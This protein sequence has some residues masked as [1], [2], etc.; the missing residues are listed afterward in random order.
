MAAKAAYVAAPRGSDRSGLKE[1]VKRAHAGL[2]V[3][4]LAKRLCVRGA[5][6]LPWWRMEAQGLFS[7][8]EQLGK[9]AGPP[10]SCSSNSH[11]ATLSRRLPPS[12]TLLLTHPPLAWQC[13]AA[14]REARPQREHH[15]RRPQ[16]RQGVPLE[17]ARGRQRGRPAAQMGRHDR[18]S[19][20]VDPS[21]G[22]LLPHI[23]CVS[24]R[25]AAL[26]HATLRCATP[27]PRCAAPR[28]AHAAPRRAAPRRAALR[29]TAPRHTHAHALLRLAHVPR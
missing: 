24:P 2:E 21:V 9:C 4:G 15:Q 16:A 5:E 29:C 23:P 8:Y 14:Q 26:R 27:R 19:H 7:I 20:Q 3:A 18:R 1:A 11:P 6:P 17:L 13:R 12:H 22:L 10:P 28:H 25:H